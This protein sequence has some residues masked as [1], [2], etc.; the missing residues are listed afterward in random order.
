MHLRQG[1]T[2]IL[3]K[4][5]DLIHVAQIVGRIHGQERLA[6]IAVHRLGVFDAL[7]DGP[8]HHAFF[9][10]RRVRELLAT[11]G[12]KITL[13][14]TDAEARFADFIESTNGLQDIGVLRILL[15]D[16]ARGREI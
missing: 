4:L 2:V 10:V 16:L 1:V 12:E 6:H 14:G 11:D 3:G 5:D 15:R 9:V 13:G 8:Q 7:L